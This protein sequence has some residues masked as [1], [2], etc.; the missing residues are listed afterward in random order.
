MELVD[1]VEVI[2]KL[3]GNYPHAT[4]TS[5]SPQAFYDTL[6]SYTLSEIL[7]I[8]PA[9]MKDHPQ[10]CPS[11]PAIAKAIDDARKPPLNAQEAWDAVHSA[12]R[13][14]GSANAKCLRARISEE[15]IWK[16]AETIG[17]QRLGMTPFEH[18]GTLF[19]QFKG[20]LND[21]ISAH[22]QTERRVMI[23]DRQVATLGAGD[24]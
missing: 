8:L 17:W 6:H 2:A 12:I 13:A 3:Q 7:G 16:A 10:Y 11:A 23:D 21:T 4:F 5:Y 15:Q 1:C 14:C 24:E 20:V 19:A 9:V 22:E 18:H